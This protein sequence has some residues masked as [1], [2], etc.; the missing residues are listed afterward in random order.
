ME[1]A[2]G[3]HGTTFTSTKWIE[4]EKLKNIVKPL[5]T[6]GLYDI[7][8]YRDINSLLLLWQGPE[9]IRR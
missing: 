8:I 7:I 4:A 3:A 1:Q 9:T 2:A 6:A 5:Q